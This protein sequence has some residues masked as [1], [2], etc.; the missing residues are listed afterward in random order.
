ML[1]VAAAMLLEPQAWKA[2]IR[3]ALPPN[4]RPETFS[5]HNSSQVWDPEASNANVTNCKAPEP[6]YNSV[7]SITV[8][9][10][11]SDLRV[12]WQ[13]GSLGPL[14]VESLNH[15]PFKPALVIAYV[16]AKPTN[17][18]RVLDEVFQSDRA[19]GEECGS[20]RP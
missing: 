15:R 3:L 10:K 11:H 13:S 6:C 1:F 16:T 20:E 9:P 12:H 17:N 5:P 7:H 19:G 2:G 8:L 4:P 18:R 14:A